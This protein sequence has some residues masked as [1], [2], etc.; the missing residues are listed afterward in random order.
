MNIET[1]E[2]LCN[3]LADWVGVYGCCKASN[4][5]SE[6]AKGCEN[7]NPLCCRVGF[8]MVM[9]ERMTKAV[10]MDQVIDKLIEKRSNS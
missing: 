6:H 7:E 4:D 10:E 1:T 3:Q 5:N 9:K 2:D 8:M